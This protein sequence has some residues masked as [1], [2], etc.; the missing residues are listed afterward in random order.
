MNKQTKVK[1]LFRFEEVIY[2][3]FAIHIYLFK[4]KNWSVRYLSL[5]QIMYS[6]NYVLAQTGLNNQSIRP[7]L[8]HNVW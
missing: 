5:W 4:Q 6:A 8:R 1:N 2:L 7:Q 3:A